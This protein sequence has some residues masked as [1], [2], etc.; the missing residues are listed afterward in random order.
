MEATMTA[1]RFLLAAILAA[2]VLTLP[3]LATDDP[4]ESELA[5]SLIYRSMPTGDQ[6]ERVNA[7]INGGKAEL[8]QAIAEA[9]QK[10]WETYPDKPDKPTAKRAR[11]N[12]ADLLSLK[13]FYFLYLALVIPQTRDLTERRGPGFGMKLLDSLN[14]LLPTDGGI[15]QAASPEFFDWVEAVRK[16]YSP[17]ARSLDDVATQSFNRAAMGGT[18][19]QALAASKTQY[20]A[21][22]IERDLWEFE[23]RD[24]I[25]SQFD[26]RERY[27]SY[28]YSRY[29]KLPCRDACGNATDMLEALRNVDDDKAARLRSDKL[30]FDSADVVRKAAK[31]PGG[32]LVVTVPPPMKTTPSGQKVEDPT[33][34]MPEGVI[35][36]YSDPVRA[37]EI[38]ATKDDDIRYLKWLLTRQNMPDG[39]YFYVAHKWDFANKTYAQLVKAFGPDE[40]KEAAKNVR[41]AKK[42]MTSNT[43]MDQNAIG[44]TRN[45]PFEAFEDI[46]ARKSAKGYVR[47]ALAL[48]QG[49]PAAAINAAYE[50]YVSS[51]NE[52]ALLEA[53]RRMAAGKPQ[54][55]YKN[56]IENIE[57][58]V[59]SPTAL[60]SE[61][62]IEVDS[63]LYLPWKGFPAGSRATYIWRGLQPPKP[64]SNNFV[65]GRTGIRSTYSVPVINSKHADVWFSEIVYDYPSGD[66]HPPHETEYDYPAKDRT[67]SGASQ[68][69]AQAP[70]QSGEQILTFGGKSLQTHWESV[71][72]Q[73]NCPDFV[74]STWT[75]VEVPG[76]LV[77][78]VEDINNCHGYRHVSE[79]LLE[80]FQGSR[81]Q[82]ALDEAAK[83]RAAAA[84]PDSTKSSSVPFPVESSAT[85]AAAAL[86]GG[87]SAQQMPVARQ[88]VGN[89]L[90]SAAT[91]P[92]LTRTLPPSGS[93]ASARPSLGV[94]VPQG[95]VLIVHLAGK[96]DSSISKPGSSFFG[97]LDQPLVINGAPIAQRGTP[98]SAQL[99]QMP[100]GAGLTLCLT[101]ITVAGRKYALATS[102][103]TASSTA[104]SDAAAAALNQVIASAGP[105]AAAAVRARLARQANT[106]QVLL[107]GARIYVPPMAPLAFTLAAP[108]VL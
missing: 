38:L 102:Q 51:H 79:T 36:V 19:W 85:Q 77:R 68:K 44:A 43:V 83:R 55:T 76:E 71:R 65:P 54:L 105:A 60:A 13:D 81:S 96:V 40:V 48:N 75:S 9:R 4:C 107:N 17:E 45:E 104:Q 34:P 27:A 80:S 103:V 49:L 22:V 35:G 92:P 57:R 86:G 67:G 97:S 30:V 95:S 100:N 23:A 82:A 14:G 41:T 16:R 5:E 101:D 20:L 63:P 108:L 66:A 94:T 64:G 42:R 24:R 3:V 74:I 31:T 29:N 58:E 61:P 33:V 6:I 73:P 25:P 8:M 87:G 93:A 37:F 99:V 32:L 1:P 89:T 11:D 46:L 69:P 2:T 56:E 47:M 91:P 7:G 78:R 72:P 26:T 18:F 90:A 70:T 28:L 59:E 52:K 10:F 84:P 39:R 106:R 88:P 50:M 21:Y 15:R 62:S 12:F 98:I 53:A